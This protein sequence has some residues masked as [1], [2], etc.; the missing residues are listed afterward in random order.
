MLLT[1]LQLHPHK[2]DATPFYFIT[3]ILNI[4]DILLFKHKK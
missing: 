2:F 1:Q 4:I 3:L